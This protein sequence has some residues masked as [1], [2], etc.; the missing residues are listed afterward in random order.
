MILCRS[1]RQ[2]RAQELKRMKLTKQPVLLAMLAAVL[3]AGCATATPTPAALLPTRLPPLFIDVLEMQFVQSGDAL[4]DGPFNGLTGVYSANQ[5]GETA[6]SVCQLQEASMSCAS[7]PMTL[8]GVSPGVVRVSGQAAG[9]ALTVSQAEPVTWDEAAAQAAAQGKRDAV[10]EELSR[11]DWSTIAVPEFGE[12]SAWF[13]PDAGR[14]KTIPLELYAYDSANDLIIW[15]GQ[16][17]EMPKQ[18]RSVYRFP[19]LYIAVDPAGV[20]PA[21]AFITIEGYTEEES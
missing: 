3:L 2:R 14:L 5:A 19:V 12:S 8:D 6:L 4:P 9:G 20:L 15:R 17:W 7:Y 13:R 10:A 16:G 18:T 11:Y 21:Q 1:A